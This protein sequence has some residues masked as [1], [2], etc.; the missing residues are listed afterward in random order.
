[1]TELRK[2]DG[3]AS[4][5]LFVSALP[6][7]SLFLSVIT[8]GEITKGVG[9]LADGAKKRSLSSWPV[10]LSTQFKERVLVLD[11]GNG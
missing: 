1:L 6:S 11:Q 3:A 10:G 2:P 4:V 7:S 8:I 9:L 5:K